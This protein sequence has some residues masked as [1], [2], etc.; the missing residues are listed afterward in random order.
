[1][2]ASNNLQRSKVFEISR[3]P[4][5]WETVERVLSSLNIALEKSE[6]GSVPAELVAGQFRLPSPRTERA[7]EL[8]SSSPLANGPVLLCQCL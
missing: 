3:G 8:G 4:T 6:K 5:Q 7:G 2:R 1:M